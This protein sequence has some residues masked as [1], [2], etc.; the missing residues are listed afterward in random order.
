MPRAHGPAASAQSDCHTER[1]REYVARVEAGLPPFEDG[2]VEAPP[3]KAAKRPRRV[4][5]ATVQ[6]A[7]DTAAPPVDPLPPT[8][9]DA[10]RPS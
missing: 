2:P 10:D 9:H 6:P 4:P 1:I 5:V 7:T 3:P 8:G